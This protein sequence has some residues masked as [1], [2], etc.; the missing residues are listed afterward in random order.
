M[1]G[2]LSEVSFALRLDRRRDKSDMS[3]AIE[4][5]IKAGLEQ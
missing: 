4:I 5:L 1:I 2:N 3:V